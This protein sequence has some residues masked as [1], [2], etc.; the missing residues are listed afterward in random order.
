MPR[1]GTPKTVSQGYHGSIAAM[2]TRKLS[3]SFEANLE[4]AIRASASHEDRSVSSWIAQAAM[5]RLRLLALGE[6]VTA[7]EDEH[8]VLTEAEIANADRVFERATRS[9]GRKSAASRVA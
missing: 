3:I 8:G 4:A 9:Q 6:A 5:Q 2:A 1:L 7:W